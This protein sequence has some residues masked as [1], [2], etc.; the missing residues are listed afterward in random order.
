VKS[1]LGRSSSVAS[2]A[3]GIT[4]AANKEMAIKPANFFDFETKLILV[5]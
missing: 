5:I 1:P 4:V 3:E 2:E